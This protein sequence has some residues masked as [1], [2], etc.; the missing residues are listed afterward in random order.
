MYLDYDV[1]P[2]FKMQV[3]TY[4]PTM[5]DLNESNAPEFTIRVRN[6]MICKHWN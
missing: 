5:L 4:I 6:G 2:E 1:A 3:N